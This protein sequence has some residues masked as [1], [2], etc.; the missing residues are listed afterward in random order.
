MYLN[1]HYHSLRVSL[2]GRF[3][4]GTKL[5]ELVGTL[6]PWIVDIALE[7][8]KIRELMETWLD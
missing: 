6:E 2:L 5:F 8:R 1:L 4:G 3:V 7:L